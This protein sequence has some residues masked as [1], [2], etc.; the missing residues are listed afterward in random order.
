[1]QHVLMKE[2]RRHHGSGGP[3]ANPDADERL[4]SKMVLYIEE[5]VELRQRSPSLFVMTGQ[6]VHRRCKLKVCGW[7]AALCRQSPRRQPDCT[8]SKEE[9]PAVLR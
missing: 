6:R 1:M 9:A 2:H 4:C 7:T 3:S 5:G 8:P